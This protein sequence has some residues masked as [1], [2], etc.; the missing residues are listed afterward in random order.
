M[1]VNIANSSPEQA[2]TLDEI[3]HF[4]IRGDL[5]ARQVQQLRD[6]TCTDSQRAK[7]NLAHDVRMTQDFVIGEQGDQA[8]IR[9]AKV[10]D[11]D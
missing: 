11:P 10:I 1:R 8:R 7:S 4:Q 3:K 9:R 5:G 6:E 2:V